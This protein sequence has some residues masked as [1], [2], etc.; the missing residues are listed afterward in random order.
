MAGDCARGGGPEQP[1][2]CLYRAAFPSVGLVA[3]CRSDHDCRVGYYYGDPDQPVWLEPPPDHPTLP[4][5]EVIWHAATFAEIR[6]A[7]GPGCRFSYFFEAKRRRVSPPRPQV[8]DVDMH[9]LLVAQAE[10][11]SLVARQIF[12]GREVARIE[13]DWA[14]GPL[15]SALTAVH[16]DPD[17]RLTFT[18]LEGADR[19]PVT[20]RVSIPSMPR[21]P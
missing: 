16:F 11:R 6:F 13:R 2:R 4:K 3:Q 18:W 15:E 10:G 19:T 8:L 12:S 17:G 5:P 1:S 14:P 7:C 9:R 21:Q 20:E